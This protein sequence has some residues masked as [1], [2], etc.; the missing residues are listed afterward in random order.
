MSKRGNGE[1]S[2]RKE[3]R[4][5]GWYYIAKV[6]VG[7]DEEG[8]QIRKTIGSYSRPEVVKKMQDIQYE[9]SNDIYISSNDI[10][11]QQFFYDWVFNYKKIE[12]SPDT[13]SKYLTAYNL[14]I[15]DSNLGKMK[16][17]NIKTTHLQQF[18]ISLL[19]DGNS[20]STC[21]DMLTR[22]KAC[23][24]FAISQDLVK[25]NPAISVKLPKTVQNKESNIKVFTKEEHYMLISN[26]TDNVVDKMIFLSLG[27]GL[28]LAE[29]IGL[30]WKDLEDSNINV[31]RQY[32]HIPMIEDGKRIWKYEYTTLKTESSLRT[33]P[34]PDGIKK[35]L[36]KHYKSQ[37]LE[38]MYMRNKYE[39][40]GV[41]FADE[42]GKPIEKKRPT[43]RLN[44]LCDELGLPKRGFHALRHSYATRLFELGV[45]LKTV[46]TLMGHSDL[47]TTQGI[48]VHVMDDVKSKA[49]DKL[50]MI[51]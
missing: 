32:R 7:Y 2:I 31:R 11:F 24:E 45:D 42:Y 6:T 47:A 5:K 17:Q 41:I 29:V 26:L 16:M 3:K 39:D 48:Y 22:I 25:K 27:T 28:R 18:F 9:I 30:K 44:K 15:K 49:V 36:D 38:K 33:V 1:G 50:N 14:R 51:I 43:R 23:F 4:A 8:K 35:M 46:Q 20:I 37:L 10:T 40:D 21:K 13:L 19:A 34:L 12:V